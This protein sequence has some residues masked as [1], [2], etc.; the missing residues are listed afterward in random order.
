MYTLADRYRHQVLSPLFV[1]NEIYRPSYLSGLW[2]LSFFG[3]I[4][5]MV[6]TYTSMT[7]R[8]PRS[9]TN[10]LGTF[11]YSHVKQSF[12]FGFDRKKVQGDQIW[13]ADPEKALLDYWHLESGEWTGERLLA[14]RFQQGDIIDFQ[15]LLGYA[16]RFSSPRL[17]RAVQNWAVVVEDPERNS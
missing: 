11:R 2:I 1:A 5:E 3:L 12:F 15:K 8:V 14:M 16:G 13:L 7:P 9:F 17:S 6:T 4:P 10:H